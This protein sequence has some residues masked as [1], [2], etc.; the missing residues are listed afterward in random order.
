MMGKGNENGIY[1][2]A[3]MDIFKLLE[4]DMKVFVSFYEIYRGKLFD[5][6]N[7]RQNLRTLEQN[8][9]VNIVGLTEYFCG[10][11]QDLISI[12]ENGNKQRATG[13]TNANSDSSRSHAILE[14]VIKKSQQLYGKI[15]F[16]DL[17]GSERGADTGETN[18]QTRMEGSEINKS[19]LALKECIRSLDQNH[20][21]IPFRGSKLTE[22]LKESFI[23]NSKT[24]M[25]ANISPSST[26]C[27]H[28]L[29]TLRYSDRVKEY[30]K[31]KNDE[32]EFKKMRDER[33][34]GDTPLKPTIEEKKDSKKFQ[35]VSP[36]KNKDDMDQLVKSH[37]ELVNKILNQ[38][39]QLLDFHK[40][41]INYFNESN[42][43]E[44][45]LLENVEQAGSQIDV[46]ITTLNSILTQQIQKVTQL[47]KFIEEFQENLIQEDEL[48]QKLQNK[49]L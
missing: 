26:C 12:M 20:K 27:E 3:A 39:E 14:I 19:L 4:K 6:L 23:G 42:K 34:K 2:L 38:E 29:N 45:E 28:S 22:V 13:S 10:S 5:L 36:F 44:I 1:L 18:R 8:N 43:Q 24:C 48:S 41:K 16:V 17:A 21:H 11:V 46:Y 32:I 7:E 30:S 37:E 33:R 47:K 15:S 40:K 9:I 49:Y 35:F 31:S 25:I